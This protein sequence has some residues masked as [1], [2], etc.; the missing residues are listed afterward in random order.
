MKEFII[1]EEQIAQ[2]SNPEITLEETKSILTSLPEI[3]TEELEIPA[4]AEVIEAPVEVVSE[5][6][7][8]EVI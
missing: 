8:E 7:G 5:M 1:N 4:E 2:I 6:L 3:K